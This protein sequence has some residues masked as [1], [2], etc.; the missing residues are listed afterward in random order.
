MHHIHFVS[1]KGGVGKSVLALALA[2]ESAARG[3]RTLLVEMNRR[4]F[5]GRALGM[6]IRHEPRVTPGGLWVANW[7]AEECLRE[8]VLHYIKVPAL[9]ELFFRNRVMRAF[10]DIAPGLPEISLL[11]KI[12]SGI[13]KV[14]P[15]LDFERVIVDCFSSGDARAFFRVPQGL[16]QA[17]Q[18]GP[19]G[20]QSRSIDRVLRDPALSSFSVVATPEELPV[21]ETLEFVEQLKNDLGRS[22][23]VIMNRVVS[24]LPEWDSP[25]DS[26]RAF[27][28][29]R[30]GQVARQSQQMERV[31][32]TLASP[33][34]LVPWVRRSAFHEVLAGV[35]E[36]VRQSDALAAWGAT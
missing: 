33:L 20:E 21:T 27:H 10:I 15:P 25:P 2:R 23:H 9:F 1:G 35:Q 34:L 17:V 36:S 30:S 31:Q 5:F 7:R 4:S 11:G 19:M 32:A 26:W 13:R 6:E 8:Y 16:A 14:G 22:S 18:V 12:T 29:F 28:T 24:S 3:H